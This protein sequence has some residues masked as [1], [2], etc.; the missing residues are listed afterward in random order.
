MMPS[1]FQSRQL[2]VKKYSGEKYI[3]KLD[4]STISWVDFGC[5]KVML[6]YAVVAAVAAL[7]AALC[8][9]TGG[10]ALIA[11]C[12]IAGLAGSALGAIVGTLICGQLVAPT[13]KW[14]GSKSN[15][16]IMGID[17]ITGDNYMECDAF[18]MLG[19][20]PEFIKFAPNIKS[21]GQAI[22]SGAASLIGNLL[23]GMMAGA[24][25]GAAGA[26]LSGLAGAGASGGWSGVGRAA[27]QFA[28]SMPKNLIG[29]FIES[30][31]GLG[32]GLRGATTAQSMLATYGEKGDATTADDLATAGTHGF[33]GMELGTVSSVQNIATGNGTL[34]DFAGLAL[35]FSPIHEGVDDL[36]SSKPETEAP[37][38]EAETKTETSKSET[39]AEAKE[40]KNVPDANLAK[41]ETPKQEGDFD[42]YEDGGNQKIENADSPIPEQQKQNQAIDDG[43]SGKT[44]LEDYGE[45]KGDYTRKGNYGEMK[46]DQHFEGL[47]DINGR[48]ADI[49][50]ISDDRVTDVDDKGHHGIDGVYENKG[51]PPP[52]YIIN[53]TKYG[54]S[55][56]NQHT[57]D[58]PQMSDPWI[59]NRLDDAVGFDK[60]E[61]IRAEATTNPSNVQKVVTV[62]DPNGNVST[63]TIDV[64]TDPNTGQVINTKIGSRW[65]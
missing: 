58:G 41:G 15:F 51:T 54:S 8:V 53:E 60:A 42:A 50:R 44:K 55:D 9:A 33:L 34:M 47:D 6:L 35:W 43:E 62:I 27:L 49:N 25:I 17:T 45:N 63:H 24:C 20:S 21:W 16:Q 13:R 57:A 36:T 28:K 56:L 11:I 19:M 48:K 18:V 59:E 4:V 46:A 3:T 61:D 12:A 32:L 10:A 65:P 64:I 23:E 26:A 37:K 30:Y 14:L 22:A 7:V 52:K 2:L 40:D 29:N 31:G 39:E 5:K 1:P 38:T